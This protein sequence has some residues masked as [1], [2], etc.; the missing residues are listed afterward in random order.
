[1][2]CPRCHQ[3]QPEGQTACSACGVIFAKW[4][5][6]Q[7]RL[8]QRQTP[9]TPAQDTGSGSFAE[10][11]LKDCEIWLDRSGRWASAL[12]LLGFVWPLYKTSLLAADSLVIW[13]WSLFGAP[14]SPIMAA[15]LA[16]PSG[17]E[18]F[19]P[20]AL[21]AL[22]AGLVAGLLR[23]AP[24]LS[25][26]AAL[27][28]SVGS[29]ALL[30]LLVVYYQEAEILGLA[31][32]PPTRGAGAVLFTFLLSAA[33]LVVSNRLRKV[34]TTLTALR[35]MAGIS[36]LLV[37]LLVGLAMVGGEG[38][39]TAWSMIL[40]YLLLGGQASLSLYSALTREVS[41]TVTTMS[42]RL[43]R[44]II[45]WSPLAVVI[46]QETTSDPYLQYVVEAGGGSL[47]TLLSASKGF[48]MYFGGAY[49]MTLGLAGIMTV[50]LARRIEEK[51]AADEYM[52]GD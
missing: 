46:A 28:A 12:L 40:L 6:H 21:V 49:L 1:M 41:E 47:H 51:I 32:T 20:W 48:F 24:A 31:F 33:F 52:E 29:A 17:K 27:M 37:G 16:T 30:L 45:G 13:P 42:S 5:E 19:L 3:S 2:E 26:R 15:A 36:G 11:I 7:R 10:Q 18:T 38:P 35:I 25:V 22:G 50:L 34:Y 9:T 4:E 8:A 14:A 39:W 23:Y 43:T 44:F